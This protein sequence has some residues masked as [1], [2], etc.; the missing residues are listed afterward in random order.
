MIKLSLFSD[1]FE[2][3]RPD[4]TAAAE[5]KDGS[6]VSYDREVFPFRGV[7]LQGSGTMVYLPAGSWVIKAGPDPG[8]GLSFDAM[9]EDLRISVRTTCGCAGLELDNENDICIVKLQEEDGGS[10]E[11]ALYSGKDPRKGLVR[12]DIAGRFGENA[13]TFGFRTGDIVAEGGPEA[14]ISAAETSL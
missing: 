3:G 14:E 13:V 10:F 9:E 6:F 11:A 2:I 7:G 5:M 8:G 1:E 4:G 12:T